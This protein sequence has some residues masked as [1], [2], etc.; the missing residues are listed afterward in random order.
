MKTGLENEEIS[1]LHNKQTWKAVTFW[2]ALDSRI[3][4][5]KYMCVLCDNRAVI[6]TQIVY[7]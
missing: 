5:L 6:N 7:Q 2:E 1:E 3:Q 4:T